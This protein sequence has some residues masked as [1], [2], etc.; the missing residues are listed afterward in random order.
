MAELRKV[1]PKR[2]RPKVDCRGERREKGRGTKQ[3]AHA[4]MSLLKKRGR[5]ARKKVTLAK[6]APADARGHSQKN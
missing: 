6:K 2:R 3:G 5:P 4:R 1:P